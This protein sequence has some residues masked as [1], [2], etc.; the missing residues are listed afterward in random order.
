MIR[1]RLTG[2]DRIREG[3][4]TN[5]HRLGGLVLGSLVEGTGGVALETGELVLGSLLGALLG[6]G[7]LVVGVVGGGGRLLLS[8]LLLRLGG[9]TTGVG[10]R[11][12]C[13]VVL[14]ALYDGIR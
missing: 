4:K 14:E 10:G 7:T 8:V 13:R 12:C 6:A 5:L 1:A 2:R 3:T 11:H 9:L